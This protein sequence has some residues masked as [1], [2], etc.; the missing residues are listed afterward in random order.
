MFMEFEL[1]PNRTKIMIN[2][3]RVESFYPS[4]DKEGNDTVVL[5]M[6]SH[7]D[8]QYRVFMSYEKLRCH[9]FDYNTQTESLVDTL[10]GVR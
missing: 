8:V 2:M 4:T 1:F 5:I 7:D 10:R 9:D 6:A 3:D